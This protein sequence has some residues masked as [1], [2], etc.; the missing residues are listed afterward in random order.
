MD[1]RFLLNF[2]T[3]ADVGNVSRA[4]AALNVAQPALSRQLRL[5]EE[6][7]GATLFL[8]HGRGVTL[9]TAGI[10][11]REHA[12]ELLASLEDARRSVSNSAGQPSGPVRLGLPTSMLYVISSDL[13]VTILERFPKIELSVVEA[14][15]HVIEGD[16]REGGLDAAI[17]ISPAKMRE[18]VVENLVEEPL[19]LAGP[20]DSGLSMQEPVAPEQ[21]ADIP[22]IMLS[23][24]NKVRTTLEAR[25]RAR[26][27][28]L[29][30]A[31]EV[32]GQPLALEL[33]RRGKGF[34]VLP[35]C[36][37]KAEIEAGRIA[38][39]PI[40]GLKVRWSMGVNRNRSGATAVMAVTAVIREIVAE[41]LAG[42]RWLA[43]PGSEFAK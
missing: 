14:L 40:A 32:Q 22:M 13:V 17:L 21:L 26:G 20:P 35:H 30:P 1:T 25:L 33:V 2:L 8:R 10:L 19:C 18:V 27:L 9:T 3:V 31:L 37:V 16:L 4:A 23:P 11:L 5:L 34:T 7:F 38:G 42:G 36:A 39:A 28:S 24:H 29:R 6:E 15:G 43:T 41:R 12:A